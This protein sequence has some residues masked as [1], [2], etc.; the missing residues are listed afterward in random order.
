MRIST[1][2]TSLTPPLSS[3]EYSQ[4]E[5]SILA[6]G[7][8]DALVTW[9]G[10]LL[11]GHHRLQICEKHGLPFQATSIELEDEATA[12]VWILKNQLGRRNL[13]P[14]QRCEIKLQ[15]E[16]LLREQA[17]ER[18]GTRTDIP[19]TLAGGSEFGDTRDKLAK[20][21]GVSHALWTRQNLST[22]KAR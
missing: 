7:C 13:A 1:R 8:R 16:E 12:K 9:N 2:F 10:I 17:K 21:A 11:D 20:E 15:L 18:Q 19:P 22:K 14:Y 3:A 4:L 6:E 5:A